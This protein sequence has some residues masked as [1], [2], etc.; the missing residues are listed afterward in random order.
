MKKP[1]STCLHQ[2]NR[3]TLRKWGNF[4]K[5]KKPVHR[6][7][8]K[9]YFRH[10]SIQIC[11]RPYTLTSR[12]RFVLSFFCR[13]MLGTMILFFMWMCYFCRCKVPKSE[14]TSSTTSTPPYWIDIDSDT[15]DRG[16]ICDDE[17]ITIIA[18]CRSLV[19]VL[20]ISLPSTHQIFFLFDRFITR[21]ADSPETWLVY[22]ARVHRRPTSLCS[23][24]H[25]R[26]RMLWSLWIRK[27]MANETYQSDV[28]HLYNDQFSKIRRL[29]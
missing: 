13:A 2:V 27:R 10:I 19:N 17:V 22:V 18:C 7:C 11:I 9:I 21:F 12:F 25:P 16:N 15:N 23:I 4:S 6:A 24:Y 20:T 1:N 3:S 8:Q 14:E 28:I 29:Y 26:T 5:T